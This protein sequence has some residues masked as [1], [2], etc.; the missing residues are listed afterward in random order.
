MQ[1]VSITQPPLLYTH[2]SSKNVYDW[3]ESDR[4]WESLLRV[5][6]GNDAI[7]LQAELVCEISMREQNSLSETSSP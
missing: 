2:W 7:H 3:N 4:S 6:R 5:A 1:H